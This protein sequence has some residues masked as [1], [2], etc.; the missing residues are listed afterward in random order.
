MTMTQN[1]SVLMVGGTGAL[2]RK[3]VDTLLAREQPVRML[4]RNPVRAQAFVDRGV[5]LVRGDMMDPSSLVAAM[6]GADAVITCA[7]GYTKSSPKDTADTDVVGNRNLVDAAA[8]VG[9]RRFVLTSILTCDQTPQVPHFWHKKLVE[10]RLIERGVP[11]VALRPGAFIETV[12]QFGCDP[13]T[14]G[15]LVYAGAERVPFTFIH[16]TD[17]AEYL[18]QA[19]D[20]PGVDGQHIDIGWT[21]PVTIEDVSNIA[22]QLLGTHIRTTVIPG[23][24]LS[25]VSGAIGWANPTIKDMSAMFRWFQSGHYVADITRQEQVFGTPPTPEQAIAALLTEL[26]HS[27]IARPAQAS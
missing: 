5:E 11:Y 14:R 26:G 17:L 6:R 7:A 8:T 19:V 20:A 2:G 23:R 9:V 25:A 13:F 16:T 15:R 10:D 12:T 18:A 1:G 22:A 3:V 4:V 24:L 27:V 21:R